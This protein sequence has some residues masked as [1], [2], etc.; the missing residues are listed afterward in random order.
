ML[1]FLP[2]ILSVI[3]LMTLPWDNKVGL[4]CAY[5]VLNFGGAPSWV[6]IVSWVTVTSAG[7]TKVCGHSHSLV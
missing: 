2:S 3:L 5:Y 6:M 1:F 7:H 4:I